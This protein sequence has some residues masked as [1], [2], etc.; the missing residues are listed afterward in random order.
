VLALALF[1]VRVMAD[2]PFGKDFTIFL[3]GAHVIAEGHAGSLY[4]LAVQGEV[5]A[6]IGGGVVYPGG[7]LPFNYPPYVGSLFLPLT[8]VP[9]EVAFYVWL[10]VQIVLI[11]AWA[12][13]VVRSFPRWGFGAPFTVPH[14]LL[15]FQPIVETL[16]MGQMSL[17]LAVLWWWALVA[18]RNERWG[19]VGVAMALAAF[20]PQMAALLVVALLMDRRWRSLGYAALTQAA[21]WLG[22]VLAAGPGIVMGYIDM[23]RT[24]ATAVNT[25]GFVPSFMPNLRGLLTVFGL[26]PEDTMWPSMAGWVVSLTLVGLLWRTARPLEVKFGLTAVLAVLFSPHLYTHDVSLLA[27]AVVCALLAARETGAAA[28]RLD[29]LLVPYVL[30]FAAMYLLVLQVSRSYVPVIFAVWALGV[31]LRWLLW[32]GGRRATPARE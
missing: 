13:W 28:R 26:S 10:G 12:A 22:A 32:Q 21:L 29:L 18:W 15:A 7:V 25:L 16:L 1:A 14:A 8:L 4:D 6:G 27:V 11:V 5:Q 19:Q 2:G 3:T 31:M 20:K 24:S 30:V 23:L 17:V 9:P